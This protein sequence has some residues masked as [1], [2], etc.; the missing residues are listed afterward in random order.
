MVAVPL[1]LLVK[2]TPEGSVPKSDSVGAGDP[3]VVTVKEKA[4]PDF[5]VSEAALVKAGAWPT[6][7]VKLCVAV[8]DALVAVRVIG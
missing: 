5:T 4:V 3:V 6:V 7:R 8:P 1:P 2:V